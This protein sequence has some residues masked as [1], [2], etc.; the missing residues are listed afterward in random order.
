[1]FFHS[2]SES[3]WETLISISIRCRR[4]TMTHI[5]F[6]TL[7]SL[8]RRDCCL[9]SHVHSIDRRK[10][11]WYSLGV[12]SIMSLAIISL[13]QSPNWFIYCM[14]IAYRM[15]ERGG[16]MQPTG[17][18]YINKWDLCGLPR[19]HDEWCVEIEMCVWVCVC[20]CVCVCLWESTSEERLSVRRTCN[21]S[22]FL[23]WNG[24][25]MGDR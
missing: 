17:F 20:D 2:I 5:A 18:V 25:W 6:P 7:V 8:R 11:S 9:L 22:K 24:K 15:R 3:A 14:L 21:S 13:S 16:S 4:K 10:Q 23:I 1:M 12:N 19:S